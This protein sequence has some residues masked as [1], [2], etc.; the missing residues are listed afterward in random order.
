MEL[1]LFAIAVAIMFHA[2][3]EGYTMTVNFEKVNAALVVLADSLDAHAEAIRN[4]QVDTASQTK[5]DAIADSIS[6]AAES[7]RGLTDEET[8][9]DTA[10]EVVANPPEPPSDE[11]PVPVD[12][13]E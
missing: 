2:L 13:Q 5:A 3:L 6:G 1:G 12:E 9:M 10:D 8:A 11:P 7:I 4:P